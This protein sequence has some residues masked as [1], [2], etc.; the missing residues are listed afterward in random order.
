MGLRELA[1]RDASR[2]AGSNGDFSETILYKHKATGSTCSI[3]AVVF[4]SRL[5]KQGRSS[6]AA[7][8]VEIALSYVPAPQVGDMIKISPRLNQT[9]VWMPVSEIIPRG[10]ADG[11]T[12]LLGVGR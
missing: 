6:N 11:G 4:R 9:P 7:I 8:E 1:A 12:T 2:L 10:D 5:G 3:S